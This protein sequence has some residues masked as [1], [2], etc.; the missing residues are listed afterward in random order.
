MIQFSIHYSRLCKAAATVVAGQFH[1]QHSMA[2]KLQFSQ[3]VS[4]SVSQEKTS[5]A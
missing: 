2:G 4:Q 1:T 5:L 3:S